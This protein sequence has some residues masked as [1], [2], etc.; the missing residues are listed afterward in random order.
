MVKNLENDGLSKCE[1]DIKT[2]FGTTK[3]R[4]KSHKCNHCDYA[5][6]QPGSLKR[7]LTAH[8]GDKPNKCNQCDFASSDFCIVYLSKRCILQHIESSDIF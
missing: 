4:N 3:N 8:S 2:P 5:C 6:V 1:S 7:H